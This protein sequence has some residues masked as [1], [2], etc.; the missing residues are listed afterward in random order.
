MPLSEKLDF[1]VA[2]RRLKE[3]RPNRCFVTHPHLLGW[4]ESDLNGWL[5]S[6]AAKIDKGY[7]PH[8]CET[9]FVPKFN[10]MVRPGSVLTL[11]DEL[12]FNAI[13]GSFHKA[14]WK[15]I[16]WAQGDPDAGYRLSQPTKTPKWVQ[17]DFR[18]WKEWRTRSLAKLT[19]GVFYVLVTDVAGFYENI[20]LGR[21]A[22]DLKSLGTDDTLLHVL[23]KCLNRWA[24]PRGK[25][26]PQGYSASDILAKVYMDPIDRALRNEGFTHLRY[27]DDIR[28]FCKSSLEAKHA[29]LTLNDA[30][31]KRGLNLQ[32]AKTDILRAD[33]ARHRID[34]ITPLI[35]SIGAELTKELRA[36]A[37]L[38]GPYG[39]LDDM[40]ELFSAIQSPRHLKFSSGRSTRIFLM[41]RRSLTRRYFITC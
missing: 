28:V 35:H 23:S 37:K 17:N 14:I 40:R 34:G 36:V 12:V 33:D 22:S 29:L 30:I 31:R 38:T 19:D 10:W 32:S 13:L 8:D 26:I 24:H 4:I 2:W 5:Q 41:R 39:T 11:E 20:D 27:V 3:D 6:V 21:L 25:G 7:S 18:I 15:G 1:D 16:G 9:C